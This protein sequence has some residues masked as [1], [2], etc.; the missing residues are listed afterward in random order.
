[1]MN[2]LHYRVLKTANFGKRGNADVGSIISMEVFEAMPWTAMG[3]LEPVDDARSKLRDQMLHKA[4]LDARQDQKLVEL[5]QL[6]F[7]KQQNNIKDLGSVLQ[8]AAQKHWLDRQGQRLSQQMPNL[9]SDQSFG[10]FIRNLW[11]VDNP[12]A[13]REEKQ[14]ADERLAHVYQS[15][16]VQ[17]EGITTKA[18]MGEASGTVGGDTVPLT[19]QQTAL[20]GLHDANLFRANGVQIV[21]FDGRECLYPT[22]DFFVAAQSGTPPLY[23]GLRLRHVPDN[24]TIGQGEPSFSQVSIVKNMLAGIITVSNATLLDSRLEDWLPHLVANA[25]S[26]HE[27]YYALNGKGTNGEPQGIINAQG[28]IKVSRTLANH[29]QAGDAQAMLSKLLPQSYATSIWGLSPTLLGDLQTFPGWHPNGPLLLHG[30][31]IFPLDMLPEAGSLGDCVLFSPEFVVFGQH[32][33][34][35]DHGDIE[36]AISHHTKLTSNQSDLRIIRRWNSQPLL[37]NPVTLQDGTT[38]TSAYVVLQ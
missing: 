34:T 13:L 2:E 5:K 14:K 38:Q 32:G 6:Q 25:L 4:I 35:T 11:M 19:I 33:T 15:N 28:A 23:G 29:F 10:D 26:W 36:L 31:P 7:E 12:W 17:W 21:G 3:Y 27:S 24:T 8:Q 16:F 9:P 30:R 1:M 18:A 20:A 37:R 22:P